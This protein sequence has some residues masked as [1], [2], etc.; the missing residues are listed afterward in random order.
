M[1]KSVIIA[2]FIIYVIAIVTVGFIGIAAKFYDETIAVESIV[3]LNEEYVAIENNQKYDGE[4]KL[5]EGEKS[6]ILKCEVRPAN[7]TVTLLDYSANKEGV[8]LTSNQDGTCTVTFDKDM[9]SVIITVQATDKPNG[10]TL[11]IRIKG[12]ADVF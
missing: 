8:T 11:K 5:K 7:A 1:K 6:L 10:V 4:I 9:A 2:L 3:C 12:K